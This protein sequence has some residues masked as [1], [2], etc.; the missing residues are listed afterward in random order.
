MN[1]A[2]TMQGTVITGVHESAEAFTDATFEHSPRF[3]GDAVVPVA[4]RAGYQAGLDIRCYE[5]DGTVKDRVWCITQGYMELPAGW[6]IIDGSL[7][8]PQIPEADAQPKLLERIERGE[9]D[10]SYVVT[11]RLDLGE[12][13]EGYRM[14]RDKQDDC[15]KVVLK[16]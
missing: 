7:V 8:E 14:F 12:A 2:L 1:Y 6:E 5:P 3:A 13:P 10:P 4:A 9:V 11:H 16:P 15:I